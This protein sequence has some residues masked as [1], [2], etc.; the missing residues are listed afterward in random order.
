MQL[1]VKSYANN[2]Q[3][4]IMPDERVQ[5]CCNISACLIEL[6]QWEHWVYWANCGKH[7]DE[8]VNVFCRSLSGTGGTWQFL[9]L[10]TAVYTSFVYKFQNDVCPK[11]WSFWDKWWIHSKFTSFSSLCSFTESILTLISYTSQNATL[12][13]CRFHKIRS[14]CGWCTLEMTS[15]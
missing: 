5:V 11:S 10:Q 4:A 8:C 2:N 1:N 7:K 12:F 13:C 14:P 15:Q 6:N 9:L 3:L